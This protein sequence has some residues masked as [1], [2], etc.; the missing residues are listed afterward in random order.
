LPQTIKYDSGHP[1]GGSAEAR[2]ASRLK[3]S[4][5]GGDRNVVTPDQ[6][7]TTGSGVRRVHTNIHTPGGAQ[8]GTNKATKGDQ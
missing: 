7:V 8:G 2:I 5:A 3:N 6:T 1:A 4:G